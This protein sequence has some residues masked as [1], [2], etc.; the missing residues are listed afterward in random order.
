MGKSLREKCPRSSHA[1]WEAPHNRPDPLRL[2]QESN[3]GRIPQL[4]P[5][6]HGRMLRT[7]FTFYR[8]AALNMAADLAVT[9]TSGLRVQACGDCHLLNFGDFA[10][11]ERRVIFDINDFDETLPAP[12][13]W[14]VKRLAASFVLACR[15]NGFS[16]KDARDA[17]LACVRSYRERMAEYSQLPV[18]DVWYASIDV[19]KVLSTITDKEARRRHQKM[20]AKARARSVLEHDFPKLAATAGKV[21]TIKDNPPL[22]YHPH[23]RGVEDLLTRAREAFAGYRESVQEDRRVL[24]DR[25]ELKDIAIKVVGVGSVG[26]FCTVT[27]MMASEQDPLF[28]QV[29]EARASVLEAYAGKSIY[30]NHGQRVVNGM[31]LMQS[32]SDIFLG[33]LKGK[34]GRHFYVRQLKDVK[35]GYLVELFTPAV[36]IQYAEVCGWTLARAHARSGAPAQ[37]SGYLGKSDAFDK[38]IA[39][40]SIAYADQSERD[41]AVLK[42]AARAGRVEVGVEPE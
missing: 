4:I 7:P 19:E 21:P 13:E 42:K 18:L 26:T 37:I 20:V 2:L 23:E 28:L 9:P 22:I 14:D 3:K 16:K 39:A 25:F 38:A 33:W 1:V 35:V 30:P 8:G 36:M 11:P 27:L 41:H 34:L 31:R 24:I 10:T 12:W 40:F 32:A 6:R 29:K 5:I 15:N 17:V